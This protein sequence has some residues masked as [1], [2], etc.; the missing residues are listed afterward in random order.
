MSSGNEYKLSRRDPVRVR[1]QTWNDVIDTVKA[2]KRSRGAAGSLGMPEP[3]GVATT[4]WVENT[5]STFGEAYHVVEIGEPLVPAHADPVNLVDNTAFQGVIPTGAKAVAVASGPCETGGIVTAVI[6]G[7]T[8]CYVKMMA[9]GDGWANPEN[10]EHR[11][12]VSSATPGAARILWTGAGGTPPSGTTLALVLLTGGGAAADQTPDPPCGLEWYTEYHHLGTVD[13]AAGDVLAP[14]A[15]IGTLGAIPSGAHAHFVL[16]DGSDFFN[17][18]DYLVVGQSLDTDEWWPW[19]KEGVRFPS[20]DPPIYDPPVFAGVTDQAAARAYIR[21]VTV[22][23]LPAAGY[24]QVYGSAEHRGGEYYAVDVTGSDV[25]VTADPPDQTMAGTAITL[26]IGSAAVESTVIFAGSLGEDVMNMVIVR[27]RPCGCDGPWKAVVRCATTQNADFEAG[28]LVGTTHDAVELALRDPILVKNQTSPGSNGIYTAN[29]EDAPTLRWDFDTTAEQVGAAVYVA[30]GTVNGKS[31]W[32]HLG[33]GEWQPAFNVGFFARL[34]SSSGGRWKWVRLAATDGVWADDGAEAGGYWATPITYD[35]TNYFAEPFEGM[36][37]WM[38]WGKREWE[39]M[40]LAPL[41]VPFELGCGLAYDEGTDTLSVD[42]TDVVFDGLY[43]DPEICALG[44]N[45]GCGITISADPEEGDQLVVD[46]PALAGD[47]TLSSLVV[48]PGGSGCDY[49]GVDLDVAYTTTE[50]V[51]TNT[52][53]SVVAG[54]LRLTQ[55]KVTYTNYFNAAGLLIDRTAGSPVESYTEVESCLFGECCEA[56]EL[57]AMCSRTPS[58]GGTDT[59][60]TFSVTPSGGVAPYAYLWDFG[61]DETSDE[62]DPVHTYDEAG[63]YSPSVTVTDACGNVVECSPGSIT[64]TAPPSEP[65][66]SCSDI[67]GDVP[68]YSFGTGYPVA[69]DYGTY[70]IDGGW[71]KY[72]IVSGNTYKVTVSAGG[73]GANANYHTDLYQGTACDAKTHKGSID[74]GDGCASFTA[75]VTGWMYVRLSENISG[76]PTYTITAAVGAC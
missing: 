41:P 55:T 6:A 11:F 68:V 37:V 74:F 65:A 75:T 33:G 3:V 16:G 76:T 13:V 72:P 29:T 8:P 56:E 18:T 50:T 51:V 67:E 39:F 60:F 58:S 2:A 34:T 64:V 42:L 14:R 45:F 15:T 54:K 21:S 73:P 69:L 17:I 47:G 44:V 62:S 36:R 22:P 35:G 32:L 48:V 52:A 24:K 53:L 23:F 71:V 40:P 30:E 49:L 26:A 63:G 5:V 46:V 57:T 4:V 59:V 38:H 43:F 70:S 10:L 12:L 19:P 20:A 1:A 66:T 31:V 9:P 25:D 61:D 28:F 27:H 7:V